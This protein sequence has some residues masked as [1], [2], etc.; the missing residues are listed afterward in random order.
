V[1]GV[2]PPVDR[3]VEIPRVPHGVDEERQHEQNVDRVGIRRTAAAQDPYR[4]DDERCERV[5]NEPPA[6]R[7]AR[8][9]LQ[10]REGAER[11]Q[12]EERELDSRVEPE[13]GLTTRSPN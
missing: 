10:A 5:A 6:E 12:E 9:A 13:R 2:V 11:E 4:R 7:L 1:V 3:V 8:E